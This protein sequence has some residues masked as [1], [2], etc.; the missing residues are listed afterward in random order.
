MGFLHQSGDFQ[1]VLSGETIWEEPSC[2]GN[3]TLPDTLMFPLFC[4]KHQVHQSYAAYQHEPAKEREV[5]VH[6]YLFNKARR[7]EAS[8]VIS[9][10]HYVFESSKRVPIFTEN[11]DKAFEPCQGTFTYLSSFL[12]T[13]NKPSRS[14]P[15]LPATQLHVA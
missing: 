2:V 4:N 5:D 9:I 15:P 1:I 7:S 8:K 10:F 13:V 12:V 14:P 6:W 3:P 11:R